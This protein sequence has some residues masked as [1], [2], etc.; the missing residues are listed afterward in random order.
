MRAVTLAFAVLA[1][2][3]P[4]ARAAEQPD[5]ALLLDLDLLRETDPRVQR[6]EPVAHHVRLLE[7]LERLNPEAA[8]RRGTESPPPGD[9]C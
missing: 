8:A 6:D 9:A 1:L 5:A 2:T 7:L 4:A 3:A